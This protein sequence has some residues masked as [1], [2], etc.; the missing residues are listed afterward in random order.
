MAV[1]ARDDEAGQAAPR[2]FGAQRRKPWPARCA[3]G[4]VFERLEAG[5]EHGGN[6]LS[7]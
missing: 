7:R 4:S 1:G 3:L 5:L 6:L 2:E